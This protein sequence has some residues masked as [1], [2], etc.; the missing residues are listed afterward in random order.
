[1]PVFLLAGPPTITL[2]VRMRR[3]AGFVGNSGGRG[4]SGGG[5]GG[6]RG[7]GGRGDGDDSIDESDPANAHSSDLQVRLLFGV[8]RI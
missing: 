3:E 2:T 8:Y 5:Y 6:R 7:G 1:M 4:R